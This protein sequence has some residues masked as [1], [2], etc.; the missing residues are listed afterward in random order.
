MNALLHP[1]HF[2]SPSHPSLT[3]WTRHCIGPSST[4]YLC[5]FLH[6]SSHSP[7]SSPSQSYLSSHHLWCSLSHCHLTLPFCFSLTLPSFL[8]CTSSLLESEPTRSSSEN[9]CCSC[10]Q[11]KA[12]LN[13]LRRKG[14]LFDD[15]HVWTTMQHAGVTWVRNAG[16]GRKWSNHAL[17]DVQQ[18]C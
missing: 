15:A 2:A 1:H 9:C 4:I 10:R 13:S 12:P 17:L 6:P 16:T 3:P 5:P 7:Q 8:W 11:Q 18:M 14:S